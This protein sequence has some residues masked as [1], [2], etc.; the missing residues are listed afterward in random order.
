MFVVMTIVAIINLI[1]CL[2]ILVL[3][4][5]RMVGILQAVGCNNQTIE[6]IFLYHA[7]IITLAGIAF[8]LLL[9]RYLF[10][11][12]LYWFYYVR[13]KQL[14]CFGCSCKNN[15]VAS[16]IGLYFYTIVCFFALSIPALLVRKI[17]PVKAI[18]FR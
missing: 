1:T 11:A 8:G 14:L 15:L 2:L 3:E 6:K 12:I 5:I 17:K 4:R 10:I 13:R 18:Q 9:G 7:S 16:N